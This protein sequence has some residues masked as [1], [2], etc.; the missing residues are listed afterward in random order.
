L[1]G[2]LRWQLAMV[3]LVLAAMWVGHEFSVAMW[4]RLPGGLCNWREGYL[5][6]A[7]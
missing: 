2:L 5:F 6:I 3:Q 7:T 4:G 1:V